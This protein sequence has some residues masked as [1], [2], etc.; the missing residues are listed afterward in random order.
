MSKLT[1]D[2]VAASV[3]AVTPE[4]LSDLSPST[5]ALCLDI[6]GTVTDYHAP[7]VSAEARA[8]LTAFRDAGY[9]TF[10]VS[11][12]YGERARE[13]HVLFD[14]LVT[15]V[16]TPVD[17]VDPADPDDTATHH[18]KPSPDMLL[19][20][21]GRHQVRDGERLRSLRTGDMVMVGDQILKD[22][23][24]ARRAG[25]LALLVPREGRGDHPA[26]RLLQRP[27]EVVLRAVLGLPVRRSGWPSAL[28]AKPRSR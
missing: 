6:D 4:A 25:A 5:R 11:N 14:D 3:P 19:L 13:V 9:L 27:L 24:A 12:C 21:A 1:P 15:E 17:C 10:V 20:A 26:V 18:R 7:T 16:V 2:F 28:A 23:V 8:A 22:V